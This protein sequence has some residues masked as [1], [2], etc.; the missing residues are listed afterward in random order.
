MTPR[1]LSRLQRHSLKYLMA[2]YRQPQSGPIPGH[3][4]LVQAAGR[5][6]SNIRHSLRTLEAGGLLVIRRTPRWAGER[7]QPDGSRSKI[8]L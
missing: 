7:R 8:G 6:K 4:Q 5:D 3:N 2:A 1:R